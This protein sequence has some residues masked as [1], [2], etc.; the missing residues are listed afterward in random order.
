MSYLLPYS[1]THSNPGLTAYVP[2]L[3]IYFGVAV[4]NYFFF[5][6]TERNFAGSTTWLLKCM[7]KSVLNLLDLTQSYCWKAREP[8]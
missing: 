6:C 8:R 5:L 7:A 1:L 4:S 3:D 2:S